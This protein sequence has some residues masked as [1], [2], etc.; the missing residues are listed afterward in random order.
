[1]PRPK[2][3]WPICYIIYNAPIIYYNN[4]KTCL[5]K[6]YHTRQQITRFFFLL[7]IS[8]LIYFIQVEAN[9]IWMIDRCM[10]III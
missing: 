1:M 3:P 7:Q 4:F 9:I 2:L 6:N 10:M 8:N 5:F